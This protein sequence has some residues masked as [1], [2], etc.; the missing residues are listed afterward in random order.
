VTLSGRGGRKRIAVDMDEVLADALGELIRRYNA[1]FGERLTKR[2]LDGRWMWDAVPPSR[3]GSLAAYLHSPDFFTDLD[4]IPES[5]RVLARLD[6]IAEIFIATAAM[7]FPNS[8]TPK[9]RWLERHFPFLSPRRFVFCGDKSILHADYLID[10]MPGHFDHFMG[11][12]LLFT[13]P[14]NTR[15]SSRRDNYVRMDDWLAVEQ[16]FFGK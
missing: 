5:Q 13:S 14:H 11:K 16:Y 6:S 1:E 10:D 8:F 2:D 4:V 9:F 7:E 15:A 12:G 3:H